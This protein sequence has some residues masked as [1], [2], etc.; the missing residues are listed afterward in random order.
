MFFTKYF[1]CNFSQMKMVF[2]VPCSSILTKKQQ[3]FMFVHFE[4]LNTGLISIKSFD[5]YNSTGSIN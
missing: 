4:K 3:F 5:T 2:V 1:S